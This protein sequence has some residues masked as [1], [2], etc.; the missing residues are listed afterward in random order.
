MPGR[1]AAWI[2]PE[3]LS[4]LAGRLPGGSI[5]VTATNGKTTTARLIA[6]ILGAAGRRIVHNRS[7][8]NLLGGVTSALVRAAGPTGRVAADVGLFEV[9]EASVPEVASGLEPRVL[10]FGN[11]FR[12]QLDR[13][14]EVTYLAG[15]WRRAVERLPCEATLVLNADDPSVAALGSAAPGRVIYVGIDDPARA[16]PE[17]EHTADARLCPRCA[18]RLEYEAVFYGHIGHYRCPA[19]GFVRPRPDLAALAVEPRGFEGTRLRL[20]DAGGQRELL[21]PLPGLYNV[22]N[23]LLALAVAGAT[24]LDPGAAGRTVER[25]GGAFGRSERIEVAGKTVLMALVKNPVGFD[26]VLRTVLDAAERPDLLIAIN[27]RLADGTDVSWLWDVE[28]EALVGRVG[29]IIVTGTRAED[30]RVRLKYAGVEPAL[31]RLEPLGARAL[32]VA[33]ERVGAGGTLYVLPTYTAMLWLRGE[34]A[35]RGH[36]PPFWED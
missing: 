34:L 28:F 13:Y 7:G 8:A 17:L 14:G 6:Q 18:G 33:L 15:Q 30:M 36:V 5:V 9:D 2:E 29:S 16:K 24:G 32:D 1:L 27:D 11:L 10:V 26:Q 31:V 4:W 20:G 19:C 3:A 35:R 25:S 22:Y 21:L 23:A 12:D